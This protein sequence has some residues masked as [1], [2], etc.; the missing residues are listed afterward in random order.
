[1]IRNFSVTKKVLHNPYY[2]FIFCLIFLAINLLVDGAFLQIFQF[3]RDLKIVR[4]R[5]EDIRT[6]NQKLKQSIKG[7]LDLDFIEKEARDR[8]D[9]LNKGE[10]IF[11][12]PDNL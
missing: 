8:L 1:M 11:I 2:V 12:F 4:N 6:N 7:S 5:V 3:S 9:F 10:L